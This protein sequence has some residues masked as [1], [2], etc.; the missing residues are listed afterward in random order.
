MEKI[1][2][3]TLRNQSSAVLR[4]AEAGEQFLITVNDRPVAVLG[5]YEPRQWIATERVRQVLESPTDESVLDDLR[6]IES[7]DLTDPWAR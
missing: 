2:Q 7:G 1:A 5:P 3:R 6:E 4:R